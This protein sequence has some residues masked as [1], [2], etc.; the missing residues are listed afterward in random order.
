[1]KRRRIGLVLTLFAV[2][3]VWAKVYGGGWGGLP[4]W[5]IIT[6]RITTMAE[7]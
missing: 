4:P 3:E 1:M 7:G 6:H 2:V 5:P